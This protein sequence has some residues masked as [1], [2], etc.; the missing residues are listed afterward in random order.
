VTCKI[1]DPELNSTKPLPIKQSFST[2]SQVTLGHLGT[3]AFPQCA[4]FND[5]RDNRIQENL[6]M[7]QEMVG[8]RWIETALSSALG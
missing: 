3:R 5:L 1:D 6:R 2:P 8:F 7:E 4:L